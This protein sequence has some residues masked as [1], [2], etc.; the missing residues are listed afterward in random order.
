MQF[1]LTSLGCK[2]TSGG[3]RDSYDYFEGFQSFSSCDEREA[4]TQQL[5][6]GFLISQIFIWEESPAVVKVNPNPNPNPW[7]LQGSRVKWWVESRCFCLEDHKLPSAP[8]ILEVAASGSRDASLQQVLEFFSREDGDRML[9]RIT[10][11]GRSDLIQ[12]LKG[13]F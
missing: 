12:N 2:N 4:S 3:Q 7:P 10:P 11:G 8:G 6:P 13:V 1:V 9:Q 5:L